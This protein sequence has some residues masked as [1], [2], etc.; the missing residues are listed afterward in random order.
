MQAFLF[1]TICVIGYQIQAT[2]G[3]PGELRPGEHC[4]EGN[5]CADDSHCGIRGKCH[6]RCYLT[7]NNRHCTEFG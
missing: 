6:V 1:L 2:L 4:F 3:K 5:K 7:G